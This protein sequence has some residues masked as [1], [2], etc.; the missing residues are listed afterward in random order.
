MFLIDNAIPFRNGVLVQGHFQVP[1]PQL[2]YGDQFI[3][4]K[5]DQQVAMVRFHGILNAN[6][7][8][9]PAN[10]RYHISVGVEK[11]FD[12]RKLIGATLNKLGS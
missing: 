8:H 6:F 3:A 5:D 4:T 1:N 10:P 9:N 7:T 12:Y 2:N 11:N